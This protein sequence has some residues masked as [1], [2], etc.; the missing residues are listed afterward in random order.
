MMC[1]SCPPRKNL[2]CKFFFGRR[3]DLT[4]IYNTCFLTNGGTYSCYHIFDLQSVSS[5]TA[6]AISASSFI[7]E[8]AKVQ[9]WHLLHTSVIFQFL[10]DIG[11]R[12]IPIGPT[13]SLGAA[14]GLS[15]VAFSTSEQVGPAPEPR[16]GDLSCSRQALQLRRRSA[17]RSGPGPQKHF[18]N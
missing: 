11:F 3:H 9:R 5:T 15:A 16:G 1:I 7:E 6:L 17:E 8:G 14:L 2:Q 12:R 13:S 4:L 18:R 10:Q